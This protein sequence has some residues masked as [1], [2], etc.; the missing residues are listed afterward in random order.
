M[1]YVQRLRIFID[2]HRNVFPE[3]W[4]ATQAQDFI[5]A[6]QDF[7]IAQ[8]EFTRIDLKDPEAVKNGGN[9]IGEKS[10]KADQLL[11]AMAL[12]M[13]PS[14]ELYTGNTAALKTLI[15]AYSVIRQNQFMHAETRALKDF[16]GVLGTQNAI[17][18][19]A[20]RIDQCLRVLGGKDEPNHSSE[21]ETDLSI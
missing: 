4:S 14:D 11:H 20:Q 17:T 21:T 19:Q 10:F 2:E 8:N 12:N 13:D 6:V 1:D 9:K 7:R 15:I 16:S 18:Y 5:T 3:V